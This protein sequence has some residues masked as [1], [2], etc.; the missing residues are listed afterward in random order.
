MLRVH[1]YIEAKGIHVNQNQAPWPLNRLQE[2]KQLRDELPNRSNPGDDLSASSPILQGETIKPITKSYDVNDDQAFNTEQKT[3]Q[4]NSKNTIS[5]EETKEIR[6]IGSK[7]PDDTQ[8]FTPSNDISLEST[9][10]HGQTFQPDLK[11]PAKNET[12]RILKIVL[13]TGGITALFF[14]GVAAY[15]HPMPMQGYRTKIVD[16]V[17]NLTQ[18]SKFEVPLLRSTSND[19]IITTTNQKDS[20]S[21]L[22]N[23]PTQDLI[24]N[25]AHSPETNHNDQSTLPSASHTSLSYN[26]T[27]ENPAVTPETQFTKVD[28]ENTNHTNLVSDESDKSHSNLA[29]NIIAVVSDSELSRIEQYSNSKDVRDLLIAANLLYKEL[30]LTIPEGNNALDFYRKVLEIDAGN[31]DA[32]NGINSIKEKLFELSELAITEGKW[33]KAK[34]HFE[35]IIIIDPNDHRALASLEELKSI[36]LANRINANTN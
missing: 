17:N 3:Q 14:A 9:H 7:T 19:L 15:E 36:E 29:S 5:L 16:F 10:E 34:R 4:S 35:K 6:S 22:T 28:Q 26:P 11:I 31:S 12:S 21:D 30:Q 23:S 18:K 13:A 32:L 24:S 2:A 27:V 25:I 1:I 20:Q 33:K 8:Y